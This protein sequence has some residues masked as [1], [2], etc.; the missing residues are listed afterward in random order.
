MIYLMRHGKDD[1]TR[2]GGWS[3]FGLTDAGRIQVEKSAEAL[4]GKGI[5]HIFSSDLPRAR[6]T[7]EIAGKKLS[8]DVS[9]LPEFR[10]VNNGVLA[11]MPK[12]KASENYPGLYF[13]SLGFDEPYPNGESPKAFFERIHDAWASFKAF[14]ADS[15]MTPLLVTHGGVINV[16]LCIENGTKFTNKV[17]MYKTPYAGIIEFE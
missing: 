8:L 11:G 3:A 10:E 4:V 12:E 15:G 5:S 14:T 7:A 6:E 9:L 1:E 13:A 16:I 17:L 2:F